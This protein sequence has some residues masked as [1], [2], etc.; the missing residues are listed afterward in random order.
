MCASML[1]LVLASAVG[2]Q[3]P[4]Q[5]V[6]SQPGEAA[7]LLRRGQGAAPGVRVHVQGQPGKP[8]LQK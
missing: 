1:F 8:S 6:A 4:G 5:T 7:G 3:L 2:G